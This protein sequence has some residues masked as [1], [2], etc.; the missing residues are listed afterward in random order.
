MSHNLQ[1]GQ[2][3][4]KVAKQYLENHGFKIM[5]THWTCRWG[6]IDIVA[7]KA[8]T[9]H[10]VEVKSRKEHVMDSMSWQK[11]NRLLRSAQ[12]YLKQHHASF[13]H[14]QID[15]IGIENAQQKI[16]INYL[17]NIVEENGRR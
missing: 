1:F 8:D 2:W 5:A 9:L 15:F 13:D 10:F 17:E 6:E 7:K 4:E 16:K 11:Q 3:G 12:V 14:Y